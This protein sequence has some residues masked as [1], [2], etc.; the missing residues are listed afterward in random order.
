MANATRDELI[1]ATRQFMDAA[2]STRWTDALIQSVL[3]ESYDNEWS[4]L[5]N[6]TPY[7]TFNSVSVTTDANGVV[8]TADLNTGSGDNEKNYYR[9][10]SMNDGSQ[11]YGET[12]F[13]H[14]PLAT[15]TSA[16]YLRPRLYY[17]AG[18]DAIQV[19]PVQSGL[20]LTVVVNYKPTSLTDL[21]T[22]ASTINFP[23]ASYLLLCYEAAATL[24]LKGG[25]EPEAASMLRG[26]ASDARRM[27]LDD[28]RRQTVTPTLLDYPDNAHEWAGA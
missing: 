28:I 1:A 22:G 13:R 24:L 21:A 5:L 27:L 9:I 3:N 20:A 18:L 12:Q 14:V 6:A 25:A 8:D 15:T 23:S 7:Y 19:L 17:R 26:L 2:G 11:L 10:L 4:N 16:V